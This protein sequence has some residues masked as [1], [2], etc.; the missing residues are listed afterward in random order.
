M[1]KSFIWEQPSEEVQAL[2]EA[3]GTDG[4]RVCPTCKRDIEYGDTVHWWQDKLWHTQPCPHQPRE[5]AVT[6][7]RCLKRQ[8]WNV[9]SVCDACL[10][11]MPPA[12]DWTL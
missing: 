1:S 9:D 7:V 8:T 6:C 12:P 10:E 5:H 2:R 3:L 4:T 11:A